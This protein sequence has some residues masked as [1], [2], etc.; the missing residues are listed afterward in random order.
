MARGFDALE[1]QVFRVLDFLSQCFEQG[2]SYGTLNNHRS[3]LSLI[4][5]NNVGQDDLVKRFFK[6][7][8]R[9]KPVFPKYSTTWDPSVVLEYLSRFYPNNT[10]SL[11]ILSKKLVVLLALATG[12]RSQTLSLIKLSNI[13]INDAK[14]II[15]ITD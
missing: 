11:E 4:S 12:Q 1:V 3:A 5:V 10:L 7:I 6:G 13:V 14:I 9:I 15:T 8:F 2:A